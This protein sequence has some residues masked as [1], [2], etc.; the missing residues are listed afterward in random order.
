MSY[1]ENGHDE[2]TIRAWR[3]EDLDEIAEIKTNI[4]Y[5]NGRLIS[6][7]FSNEQDILES[8]SEIIE[9]LIKLLGTKNVEF[10]EKYG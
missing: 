2:D 4:K 6:R 1:K 8:L 7:L 10:K 9:M 5:F 3:R